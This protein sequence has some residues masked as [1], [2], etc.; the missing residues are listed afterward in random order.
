MTFQN[1]AHTHT[2]TGREGDEI[3]ADTGR[4]GRVAVARGSRMFSMV[5][6]KRRQ[7]QKRQGWKERVESRV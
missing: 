5:E 3:R 6:E 4:P 2:H 7:E 1:D